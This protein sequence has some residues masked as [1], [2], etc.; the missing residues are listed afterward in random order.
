MG[1]P[2]DHLL[3]YERADL[4]KIA[5]NLKGRNFLLVHGTADTDVRPQHPIM[6]ARALIDQEVLFRQLVITSR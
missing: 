6:L 5:G 1:S 2:A 4:T 3:D